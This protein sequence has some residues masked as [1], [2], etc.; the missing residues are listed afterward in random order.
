MLH[1][2]YSYLDCVVFLPLVVVVFLNKCDFCFPLRNM[3]GSTSVRI[4][5]WICVPL[6]L[7]CCISL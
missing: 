7:S 4:Q 2:Y 6:L 5:R 1:M 3:E